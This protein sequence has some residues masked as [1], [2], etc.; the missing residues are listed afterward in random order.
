[1]N[2]E[3]GAF[4]VF[5][6]GPVGRRLLC[7]CIVKASTPVRRLCVSYA[8]QFGL[9]APTLR[10]RYKAHMFT[11]QS[12]ETIGDI[13]ISKGGMIYCATNTQEL[14]WRGEVILP[15]NQ[16]QQEQDV[17]D[18]DHGNDEGGGDGGNDDG[19][20]DEEDM[21]LEQLEKWMIENR[22]G[23]GAGKRKT[24]KLDSDE[25]GEEDDGDGDGP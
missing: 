7:K 22:V 9:D 25:E 4:F 6:T 16:Q 24:P 14:V 2:N 20:C 8:R 11:D 13:G 5:V 19:A 23:V 21:T 12:N 15:P 10:F 3:Q 1:M 18:T 17:S